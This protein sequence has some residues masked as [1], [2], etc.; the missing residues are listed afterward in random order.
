MD[1]PVWVLNEHICP[2]P[3]FGPGSGLGPGFF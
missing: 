3:G 1:D 2:G